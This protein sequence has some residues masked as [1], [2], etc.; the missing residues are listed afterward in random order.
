[1]KPWSHIYQN[2]IH[3]TD[4]VQELK[5][6]NENSSQLSLGT[7]EEKNSNSFLCNT[8]EQEDLIRNIDKVSQNPFISPNFAVPFV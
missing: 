2:H 3:K 1:M 7:L 5:K 4:L 8:W 6:D